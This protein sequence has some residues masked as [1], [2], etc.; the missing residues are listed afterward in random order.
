MYF[1]F[2]SNMDPDTIKPRLKEFPQIVRLIPDA[3]RVRLPGYRFAFNKYSTLDHTGKANIVKEDKAMVRGVLFT[4][5]EFALEKLKDIEKGYKDKTLYV[6]SD[7][8]EKYEAVTFVAK[9]IHN[10]LKPTLEYLKKILAGANYYH[11]PKE[12]INE[13]KELA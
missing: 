8:N 1:A 11:L 13:I 10:G 12:Y 3:K 7:Q 6:F 9:K 5:N 2:G 4:F